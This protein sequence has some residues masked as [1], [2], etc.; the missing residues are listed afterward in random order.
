MEKTDEKLRK[1]GKFSEQWF[2]GKKCCLYYDV[3]QRQ[4]IIETRDFLQAQ[5]EAIIRWD[6]IFRP[7]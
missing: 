7:F 4:V 1:N 6:V 2:F 5:I 3:I